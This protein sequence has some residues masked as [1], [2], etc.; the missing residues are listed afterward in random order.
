MLAPWVRGALGGRPLG[1]TSTF[2][3]A[4]SGWRVQACLSPPGRRIAM[5]STFAIAFGMSADAFA[6]SLGKGAALH[7]PQ[8]RE[9]LRTGLIF[10]SVESL[11]TV[12]GWSVGLAASGHVAAVDHWIAFVLLG[13]IGL[14]MLWEGATRPAAAA[15]VQRHSLRILVLTALGASIDASA[16][17]MTLALIGADIVVTALAVG[18]TTCVMSGAGMALGRLVGARFGR[19]AEV[20]GGLT[21]IAVGTSILVSHLNLV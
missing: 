15:R 13:A 14:K 16:V 17:G 1:E 9:I 7:R 8:L 10:G 21:L 2:G 5:I 18:V 11:A 4:C 20:F 6:A 12:L 3:G 19:V